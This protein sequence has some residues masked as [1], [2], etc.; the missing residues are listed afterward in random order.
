MTFVLSIKQC[1]VDK[2]YRNRLSLYG[3]EYLLRVFSIICIFYLSYYDTTK[4][5]RKGVSLSWS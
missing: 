5:V 4:Q 2:L 3:K 1:Q